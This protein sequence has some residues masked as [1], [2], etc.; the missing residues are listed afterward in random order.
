MTFFE[1]DD[2]EWIPYIV[3]LSLSRTC[4]YYPPSPP[5]PAPWISESCIKIKISLI[6]FFRTTLWRIKRFY[7]D[8][9]VLR[10]HKEVWR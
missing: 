5:A 8:L 3:L 10:N 7:E 9:K 2:F 1:Y 4:V 6:F